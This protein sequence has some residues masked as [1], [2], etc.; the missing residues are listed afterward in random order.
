MPLETHQLYQKT[1]E[2][3]GH[4][5]LASALNVSVAHTYNLTADPLSQNV[6]VRDDADR[7]TSMLE[8]LSTHPHGK[9]A[10]V[11]WELHFSELFDR[12]VRRETP[13]PLTPETVIT[14]AQKAITEFGELLRECKPGFVPEKLAKEAAEL[15]AVL[16]RIVHM[17][18][19][20]DDTVRAVPF[21]KIR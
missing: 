19:T 16:E 15:I 7:L 18:E 12:L 14:E 13:E 21:R 3:I 20:S 5:R 2:V 4:K 6:A 10:L 1:A 9:P 8:A 17:A 11:L